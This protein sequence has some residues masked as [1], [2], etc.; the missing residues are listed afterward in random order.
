M[1]GGI[2]IPNLT[3]APSSGASA[4]ATVGQTFGDFNI[5]EVPSGW[6]QYVPLAVLALALVLLLRR[7]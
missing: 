5:G 4:S 2:P 1:S 7:G 6:S 3:V